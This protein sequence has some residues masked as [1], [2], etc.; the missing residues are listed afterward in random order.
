LAESKI[1]AVRAMVDFCIWLTPSLSYPKSV[2][3][4]RLLQGA[5]DRA[6][7]HFVRC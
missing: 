3:V 4:V 2:V 7:R 6:A 5:L 1:A